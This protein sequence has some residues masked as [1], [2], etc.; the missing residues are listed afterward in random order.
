MESVLLTKV[1]VESKTICT[2]MHHRGNFKNGNMGIGKKGNM[3]I[4]KS[5]T[6]CC[7]TIWA[8]SK[9]ESDIWIFGVKFEVE[10]Y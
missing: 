2:K 7:A 3:G 8:F 5:L 1:H 4:G 9:I 10:I 6:L